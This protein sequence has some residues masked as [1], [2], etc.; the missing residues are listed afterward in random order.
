MERFLLLVCAIKIRQ[1]RRRM[2]RKEGL[3][4]RSAVS[5][6]NVNSQTALCV[7]I[8]LFPGSVGDYL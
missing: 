1:M 8:S 5:G 3:Y 2:Y 4:V 6:V 7:F